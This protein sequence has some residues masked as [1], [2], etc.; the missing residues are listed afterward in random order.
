VPWRRNWSEID[1]AP[2][3]SVAVESPIGQS[4]PAGLHAWGGPARTGRSCT[5]AASVGHLHCA[6]GFQNHHFKSEMCCSLEPQSATT[7]WQLSS[8]PLTDLSVDQILISAL[9]PGVIRS[10]ERSPSENRTSA[11]N[12]T[13]LALDVFWKAISN[14]PEGSV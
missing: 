13:C 6:Q 3:I 12:P 11:L 4:G 7:N 2:G 8:S 5:Y 9:L 14:T 1:G 10:I